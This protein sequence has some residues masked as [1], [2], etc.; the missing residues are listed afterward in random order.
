MSLKT[1]NL[2]ISHS[3]NYGQHYDGLC[4]LLEETSYF[5]FKN[6]SVSRDDP[7]HTNGTEE[8]LYFAIRNQMARCSVILVIAGVYSSYSEWIHT[9]IHLANRGFQNPKPIIAVRP[10]RSIRISSIVRDAAVEVVHWN[11]K[12]IVG[13]IRR[14][15]RRKNRKSCRKRD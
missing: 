15:S 10:W 2:F 13:A 9:E 1:Y 5:N 7:V 3:W 4:R 6:Y 14:Y 11:S 8:D 12:S